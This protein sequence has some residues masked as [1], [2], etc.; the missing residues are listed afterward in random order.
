MKLRQSCIAA[1]AFAGV[2]ASAAAQLPGPPPG[3]PGEHGRGPGMVLSEA[4]EQKAFAIRHAAEPA[5]F[6]QEMALRK[7]H[8]ALRQM[9]D[10]GQFDEA[11]AGAAAIEIGNASAALALGR[12]RVESQIA[13]LLTPEQRA[14]AAQHHP[15]R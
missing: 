1:L 6:E 3:P 15:R 2:M 5:R 12:A 10:S 9:A 11:K 7:A 8:D 4:Q 14:Q 13:A